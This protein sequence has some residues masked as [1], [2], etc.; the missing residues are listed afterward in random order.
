MHMTVFVMYKERSKKSTECLPAKKANDF[1]KI[2]EPLRAL[3]L[4]DKCV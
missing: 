2:T 4:V 3:S 1:C